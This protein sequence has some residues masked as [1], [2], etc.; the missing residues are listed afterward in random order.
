MGKPDAVDVFLELDAVER[1]EGVV[2]DVIG[3]VFV[4]V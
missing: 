1:C 4:S 2:V 3:G